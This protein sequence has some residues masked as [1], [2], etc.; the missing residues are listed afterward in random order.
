LLYC[1][2]LSGSSFNL[3]FPAFN[4]SIIEF[5]EAMENDV[6]DDLYQSYVEQKKEEE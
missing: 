1:L 6:F 4:T 5:E 3:F 2:F